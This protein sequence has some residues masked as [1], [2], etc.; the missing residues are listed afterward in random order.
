[1]EQDLTRENSPTGT[2]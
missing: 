1:M 2:K